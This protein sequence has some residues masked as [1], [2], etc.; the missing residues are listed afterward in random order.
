[1]HNRFFKNDKEKEYYFKAV[2]KRMNI[3]DKE[4]W[5]EINEHELSLMEVLYDNFC[6]KSNVDKE[7]MEK[8]LLGWIELIENQKLYKA[9]K[10]LTIE[11]QI[12]ISYIVKEGI[13][14]RE[15][16][17]MYELTQQGISHKFNKIIINI[18]K[19]LNKI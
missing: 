6:D 11:D 7:L 1:M 9:L 4:K 3:K 13:K 5:D 19:F 12:F 10:D 8:T 15:L 2:V 18:N 17:I 14:Q 16:S